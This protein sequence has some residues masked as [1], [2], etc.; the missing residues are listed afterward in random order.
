MK[1]FFKNGVMVQ[2]PRS[3]IFNNNTYINP[4]DKILIEA[5]YEIREIEVKESIVTNEDIKIQRQNA[6]RMRADQYLISYQA[7][8]ELGETDKALEMKEL[9]LK[10][11]EA[12][13]KEYPY[14]TE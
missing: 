9:W 6:Y 7:Y 5:G 3:I 14:I 10:E 4:S 2:K 13:D 11:R 1:R 12:I 8:K